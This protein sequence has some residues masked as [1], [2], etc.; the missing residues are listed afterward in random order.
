MALHFV[1]VRIGK[2]PTSDLHAFEPQN[3]LTPNS[4]LMNFVEQTQLDHFL[5]FR[6]DPP[7]RTRLRM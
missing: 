4:H 6:R 3:L 2:R 5:A 7:P 1:F